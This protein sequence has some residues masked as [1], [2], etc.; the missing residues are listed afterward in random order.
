MAPRDTEQATSYLVEHYQP[1]TSVRNLSTWADRLRAAAAEMAHEGEAIRLVH[2][3]IV[4]AD[5]SLLCLFEAD[6]EARVRNVYGRAGLGF[7]RISVALSSGEAERG[8][9]PGAGKEKEP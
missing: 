6:S 4:P 8:A 5:E 1:G 2:A 9:P 3:T 7:E